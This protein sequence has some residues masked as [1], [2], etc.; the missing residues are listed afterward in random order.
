MT[1]AYMCE[2]KVR[3]GVVDDLSFM[4]GGIGTS[5]QGRESNRPPKEFYIVPECSAGSE[6]KKHGHIFLYIERKRY[7]VRFEGTLEDALAEWE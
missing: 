6:E 4:S 5:R 1:V 3:L 7:M 2:G